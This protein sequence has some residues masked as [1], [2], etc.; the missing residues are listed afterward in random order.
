MGYTS[1]NE[2]DN[3]LTSLVLVNVTDFLQ[4]SYNEKDNKL[5][6]FVGHH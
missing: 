3:K 4:A 2:K 5:V 1:Y 6:S